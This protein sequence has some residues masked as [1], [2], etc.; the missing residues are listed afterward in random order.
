MDR[1]WGLRK[2]VALELSL[3]WLGS[4]FLGQ[5]R[6]LLLLGSTRVSNRRDK[7][8]RFGSNTNR[9]P[10]GR[11]RGYILRLLLYTQDYLTL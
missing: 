3:A 9:A 7:A 2:V 10:Q 11:D 8:R 6:G 5:P 1:G 4:T